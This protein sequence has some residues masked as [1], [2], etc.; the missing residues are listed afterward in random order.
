MAKCVRLFRVPAGS[1]TRHLAN[2]AANLEPGPF[3]VLTWRIVPKLLR[4]LQNACFVSYAG[5]PE[6]KLRSAD[7][8]EVFFL[9]GGVSPLYLVKCL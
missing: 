8:T 6:F 5:G 9:G 7:L 4:V 2:T 3:S 1:A